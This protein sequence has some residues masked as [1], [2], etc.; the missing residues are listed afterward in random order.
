[1]LALGAWS[2]HLVILPVYVEYCLYPSFASP[3]HL[4]RYTVL[5]V[6]INAAKAYYLY[7]TFIVLHE[8]T[9]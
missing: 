3:Y 7:F 4:L 9:V 6:S 5:M 2:L 1:M 8:L